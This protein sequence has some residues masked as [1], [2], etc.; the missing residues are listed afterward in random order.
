MISAGKANGGVVSNNLLL[1]RLLP[2]TAK[3]PIAVRFQIALS[4]LGG[5]LR[6]CGVSAAEIGERG[7]V[8]LDARR[9]DLS[10]NY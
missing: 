1:S 3:G 8:V 10:D 2:R 5:D 6:G 9:D 4:G 7:T